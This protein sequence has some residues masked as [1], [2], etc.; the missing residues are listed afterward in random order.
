[1]RGRDRCSVPRTTHAP[2]RPHDPACTRQ[3]AQASNAH[4]RSG[5]DTPRRAR[6]KNRTPPPM[7]LDCRSIPRAPTR[8][9]APRFLHSRVRN[10][11]AA[12]VQQVERDGRATT[13][14]CLAARTLA[15]P[16]HHS[17]GGAWSSSS[18]S[19]RRQPASRGALALSAPRCSSQ[20]S[21]AGTAAIDRKFAVPSSNA[22]SSSFSRCVRFCTD[23]KS[24]V[25]PE[26]QGR[27]QLGKRVTARNQRAEPGR[28]SRTSCRRRGPRNRPASSRRLS[29]VVGR[30]AAA[31]S[32]TRYPSDC[33]SRTSD[34]GCCTPEKFDCAGY[35]NSPRAC[36]TGSASSRSS[37]RSSR[38]SVV[39]REIVQRAHPRAARTH[40]CRSPSCDCRPR[41][42]AARAGR[43][44]TPRATSPIAA[45][46]FAVK[47]TAYSRSSASRNRSTRA[48]LRRR[49]AGARQR[50]RALRVR[51]AE[52]EPR[53][54][55]ACVV[56]AGFPDTARLRCNRDTR[57][58]AASSRANS[59]AR[60]SAKS[61]LGV[62]DGSATDG[63]QHPRS[64]RISATACDA[65]PHARR[66]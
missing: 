59:R 15:P 8:A 58:P 43:T 21:P 47:Q 35:A 46:A 31:S 34:S 10:H 40:E 64:A 49:S 44:G 12:L 53:S 4:R 41:A 29:R 28:D 2:R 39:E 50:R 57:G 42:P 65:S 20:S 54:I 3:S 22:D 18:T 13:R 33:A 1:M 37:G 62:C 14:S 60:S 48:A 56:D 52:H 17:D 45:V 36:R 9:P 6:P 66:P 38:S 32:S 19:R 30:N 27:S 16:A 23:T 5:A 7:R 63:G 11:A 51:V 24:T 61:M 25:P 26:N 55:A